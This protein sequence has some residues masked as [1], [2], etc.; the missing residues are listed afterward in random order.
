MMV[1]YGTLTGMFT[2]TNEARQ[3]GAA[4]SGGDDGRKFYLPKNDVIA[5]QLLANEGNRDVLEYFLTVML[6]D[7]I[8]E[9][10][11]FEIKT[12]HL[13]PDFMGEKEFIVD[14]RVKMKSGEFVLVEVQ[15]DPQTGF[16]DRVQAY[17]A[18]AYGAQLKAGDQYGDIERVI[19]IIIADFSMFDTPNYYDCF[20]M[21][22]VLNTGNVLSEKQEVHTFELNKVPDVPNDDLKWYWLMLFKAESLAELDVLAKKSEQLAHVVEVVKLFNEDENIRY[23]AEATSH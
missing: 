15:R 2:H 3:G 18:R 4:M 11:S 19:S 13:I 14:V 16:N 7:R 8:N 6:A 5:H 17:N 23:A 20:M 12:P 22:S 21:S 9:F 10:Q 1:A